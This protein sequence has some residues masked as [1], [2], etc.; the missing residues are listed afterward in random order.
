VGHLIQRET[1]TRLGPD[2]L[3][4]RLAT[5]ETDHALVILGSDGALF[6]P[7]TESP[8]VEPQTQNTPNEALP[9]PGS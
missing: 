4:T 6:F 7:Y 1:G 9:A 8:L 2:A 3:E 5:P